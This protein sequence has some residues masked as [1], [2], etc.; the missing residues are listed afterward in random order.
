MHSLS[1]HTFTSTSP[2]KG[3]SVSVT[4]MSRT[5]CESQGETGSQ[6]DG[7]RLGSGQGG[8]APTKGRQPDVFCQQYS[9]SLPKVAT[10]AVPDTSRR[11]KA[12]KASAVPPLRGQEE[13]ERTSLNG[14]WWIDRTP[15]VPSVVG[16]EIVTPPPQSR[17]DSLA[18]TAEGTGNRLP[19]MSKQTGRSTREAPIIESG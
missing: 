5:R 9:R 6:Q 7:V 3:K 17:L 10:S 15:A 1:P 4:S 16:F 19:A 12:G 11:R 13:G 18:Q 8:R 14:Q 2:P